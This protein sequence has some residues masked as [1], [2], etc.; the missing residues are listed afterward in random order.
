M[1]SIERK[2]QAPDGRT[3][4]VL[5]AGP[6][7]ADPI[8]FLH[9]TPGVLEA[10]EPHVED[11]ARRGMRHVSYLRPGYDG[12][13]RKPGRSIADCAADVE[14]IADELGIER[15]YVIGESGGGAHALACA[16][17]LSTRVRAVAVLAGAA[18]IDAEDWEEGMGE[19]NRREFA[20]ARKGPEPLRVFLE[21]EIQGLREVESMPQLLT[22]L[23]GHLCDADRAALDGAFGEH[24]LAAWKRIGEG[25]VEGWLDD[26]L[27]HIGDWGFDF[28][29]V[30]APV[31]VWQGSAD[32]FVP[33][34]H[35]NWL[36][37][38]L[39]N[40]EFRLLPG[41]GHISLTALHYG[42]ALD[43]LVASGS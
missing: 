34:K 20:A 40:A 9:G 27:A 29:R 6:P 39:P 41:V 43:A 14:A 8:F 26:D 15:F 21:G 22:A 32:L 11:G 17:L 23:D 35:G 24:V 13:D 2:V 12:S 25:G 16:A 42:A 28:E 1:Q 30:V 33:V 5:T 3:L 36:A 31:T 19:G 38:N 10:Y 37:K 18:P 7:E 4:A